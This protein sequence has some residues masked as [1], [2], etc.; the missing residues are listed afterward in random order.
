MTMGLAF[1]EMDSRSAIVSEVETVLVLMGAEAGA[2][3]A[4]QV[5]TR[6]D[7]MASFIVILRT[8]NRKSWLDGVSGG[9][10]A[11]NRARKVKVEVEG[12]PK[13]KN[14]VYKRGDNFKRHKGPG[15]DR[16]TRRGDGTAR[17]GAPRT[18]ASGGSTGVSA[19]LQ[20]E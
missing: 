4:A 17:S 1:S 14:D 16:G 9:G 7:R 10:S 15:F 20:E 3:K 13:K 18:F 12:I 6:V 8:T 2:L 5:A 11:P 19:K